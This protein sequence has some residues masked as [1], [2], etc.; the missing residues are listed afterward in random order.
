MGRVVASLRLLLNAVLFYY[1]HKELSN[2]WSPVLDICENQK[3][4][5]TGVYK[6]IR[7]PMYT[8]SWLWVI[9]QGLVASNWFVL[10]FGIV[11]WGVC[12]LP[13]CLRKKK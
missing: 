7:H 4:I 12:T 8:Q 5:K 10:V 2:N 6:Y 1:V 9:L 13:E 11:T 3:I